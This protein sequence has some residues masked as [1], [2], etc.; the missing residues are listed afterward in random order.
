MAN[1]ELVFVLKGPVQSLLLMLGQHVEREDLTERVKTG[2]RGCIE[3]FVVNA[4]DSGPLVTRE[5]LV[6]NQFLSDHVLSINFHSTDQALKLLLDVHEHIVHELLASFIGE[7]YVEI[8]LA[9]ER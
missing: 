4:I 9:C 5:N 1:V 2:R 3:V 8:K 7:F 6:V